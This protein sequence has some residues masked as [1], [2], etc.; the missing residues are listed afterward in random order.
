MAYCICPLPAAVAASRCRLTCLTQIRH[1]VLGFEMEQLLPTDV[2]GASLAD[3][4]NQQQQQQLRGGSDDDT[5]VLS[6]WGCTSGDSGA[7][8]ARLELAHQLRGSGDGGGTGGGRGGG[9]GGVCEQQQQQLSE[10]Q[11]YKEAAERI[12]AKIAAGRNKVR[13]CEVV[14]TQKLLEVVWCTLN[15]NTPACAVSPSCTSSLLLLSHPSP[16][17]HFAASLFLT[18]SFNQPPYTHHQQLVHGPSSKSTSTA[19]ALAGGAKP[20]TSLAELREQLES[21]T[22]NLD[23]LDIEAAAQ[24]LLSVGGLLRLARKHSSYMLEYALVAQ[25]LL[26]DAAGG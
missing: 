18:S 17:L 26:D 15:T 9:V 23:A 2:L 5:P 8:A 12:R 16:C 10:R 24:Q 20:P 3:T 4:L 22:L 14:V 6:E 25:N 13:E 7:E 1:G 21:G 11:K 19:S